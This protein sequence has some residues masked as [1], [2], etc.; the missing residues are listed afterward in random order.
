MDMNFL[1]K[2]ML[3][4]FGAFDIRQG[5]RMVLGGKGE[6]D[7]WEPYIEVPTHVLDKI[8]EKLESVEKNNDLK[9]ALSSVLA[10]LVATKS[11]L[12]RAQD[13]KCC[14]AQAAASDAMFDH[15][16]KDYDKAAA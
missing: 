6:E 15:M 8:R 12:T 14:P 1:N 11:L 16:L 10:S 3:S 5:E 7:A 13:M 2:K 4:H 9:E